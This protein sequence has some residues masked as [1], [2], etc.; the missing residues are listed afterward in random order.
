MCT[1]KQ[2]ISPNY[3]HSPGASSLSFYLRGALHCPYGFAF[4]MCYSV[5]CMCNLK[6]EHV[7]NMRCLHFPRIKKN[8]FLLRMPKRGKYYLRAFLHL[9]I[10]SPRTEIITQFSWYCLLKNLV[11]IALL[12]CIT[13]PVAQYDSRDKGLFLEVCTVS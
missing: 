7:T 4:C 2:S 12:M 13:S 11:R 9:F 3:H 6:M 5:T 1:H 10:A 8:H